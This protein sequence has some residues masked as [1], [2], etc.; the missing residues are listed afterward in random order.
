MYRKKPLFRRLLPW[1]ITLVVLGALVLFVF[2]PIYSQKEAENEHPPTVSYYEGESKEALTMEN[3]QL[4]FEMDP[5]TT[6]FKITQKDS[7][8]E[9]LSNPADAEKDPI[10]LGSNKDQLLSTLIVTYTTSG[11]EVGM[12]NYTYSMQNQTYDVGYQED[13]SIRVDYSVGAIERIYL[14][15]TAITKERYTQFTDAMSKSSKKKVSSNYTLIEPE[16]LDKRDD[17]AELIEKYPSIVDQALYILKS[18]TSSTNKG[19]L[20]GYFEEGGYNEEEFAVDQELVAGGGGTSGPVFNVTMVYR[21]HG[22]DLEVTIPYNEIRYKPEYPV[23]YL[24]PLPMFGAAGT[25]D[26]GY[27]FIPEGGGAIINYNNGKLSQTPYYANLYGWDYGVQRQEAVSET[28]NAF[29]VFGATKDGGSFICIME[30]ASS[31]AGVN[32]DISG[33]YN[34]YN[35]VYAK[36]NVLH[37]ETYNVSAKTTQL[38]YVYEK[39]L[40]RDTI[41][42]RYRFLNSDSYVDMANAYGDYL[43]KS[44]VQLSTAVASEVT[45]V[46]VELIGAINKK[47]VKMGMPVDSVVATTTFSQAEEILKELAA[48]GIQ[49]LNVRMTGWSNGGVRQKVL[50]RVQ[51]VGELGGQQAMKNL[52]QTAKN[53][54]VKLFL[55]GISCF[56]YDSG[57]LDG[58]LPFANAARYATREQVHLY[59]YNIVTYQ[60]AEQLDDY[61]LVRPSFASDCASHLIQY[62]RE[63][64]AHGVAFRDVGNLLSADYYPRDLVTREQVK[65]MNVDS[66]KEASAAGQRVMIKEGNDYALPYVDII[67]DMN[68]T[69]QQ[70]AII[71][72]RVPFYQIALHGMKDFTGA[73]INLSGDYQNMLL[74][75]AEYGAG[76]NFT[77]MAADTRVLKESDYSCYTSSGY[78]YWKEKVIPMILRYQSETAGLNTQR[79]IGHSRLTEDVTMTTYADGSRVYV[80]YGK[81]AYRKGSLTIPE[82]DYLVERGDAQ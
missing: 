13:G 81:V 73:A 67:T 68:L 28:E 41:V 54:G 56:A 47:V 12:N 6:R 11:G 38:V 27:M 80:N 65:A 2:V 74:E 58:F 37:A 4:L 7:G 3:E 53:T 46:N 51:A 57:L 24:S 33:R 21:L 70:Y 17:K 71:D 79:I 59:P 40:P 55:D 43:R 16:K 42:Q 78:T 50:T 10:A 69:G 14:I 36:Y 75:C 82:L 34:S 5:A 61:Y 32:A 19:K 77:F 72:E 52:I 23:T 26:E 45:P 22:N 20:E 48:D 76:L 64:G 66:L 18:D 44:S 35:T 1:L 9:W 31:Y 25:Q 29:P 49:D 39:D 30:G 60:Q 63:S 15:P 62:I 8:R